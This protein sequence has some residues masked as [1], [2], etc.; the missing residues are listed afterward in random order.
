MVIVVFLDV[1]KAYTTWKEGHL[2]KLICMV[3]KGRV[4]YQIKNLMVGRII[5]VRIG[6]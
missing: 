2:V 4:I 1:D 6:N 5:Q 3:I